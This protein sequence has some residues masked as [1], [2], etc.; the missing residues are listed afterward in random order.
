MP[1]SRTYLCTDCSHEFSKLHLD[2]EERE[3]EC[4]RCAEQ[5]VHQLPGR[6]NI[7]TNKG[8]AID[9]VQKMAEED[10]G[11]TDMRDNQRAGDIAAM[12]PSHMQTAER[13]Q[14]QQQ[15]AEAIRATAGEG[16]PISPEVMSVVE[17]QGGY[18]KGGMG[19]DTSVTS[20]AAPKAPGARDNVGML[21]AARDR[22]ISNNV[23]YD[24]VARSD[25][26]S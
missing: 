2:R 24:V 12:G 10:Y 17:G 14:V 19:Q 26:K 11:L 25:M 4:P 20:V 22:G 7:G 13:E 3:T 23:R 16:T 1:V 8:K 21:E 18:W 15:I 6:I 9:Y 5:T